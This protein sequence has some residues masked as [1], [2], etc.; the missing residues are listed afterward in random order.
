M[1]G[2]EPGVRSSKAEINWLRTSRNSVFG[3]VL[4]AGLTATGIG[5]ASTA[6]ATCLSFSGINIGSGCTSSFLGLAVALGNGAIANA[7]GFLSASYSI[8]NGATATTA[9]PLGLAVAAGPASLA[10]VLGG[11]FNV[12]LAVGATGGEEYA[13]ADAG[14]SQTDFANLAVTLGNNSYAF[15]GG[16][17]PEETGAGNIAVNLGTGND[18][19]AIGFINGALAVG[20]KEPYINNLVV[21]N[22]VFNSASSIFG[23]RNTV[24]AGMSSS[25]FANSA[26]NA[27]GS[28][29]TVTAGTG[30]L[31]LAGSMFQ[32]DATVTKTTPGVNIN[33]I[34]VPDTAASVDVPQPAA[35]RRSAI[36]SV[37]PAATSRLNAAK[38]ASP[39]SA[40]RRMP[41]GRD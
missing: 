14:Y 26:F 10:Q 25:A 30:P 3:V 8:G 24:S 29:N 35:S 19:E 27:F 6:N 28:G 17:T 39:A 36:R 1:T 15:A 32:K 7:G 20:G 38:A 31:T 21:A 16:L 23:D 18:V 37:S 22:G 11:A 33:G 13:Q 12:A 4:A 5:S 2:Q 41:A 9:G 40:E 34:R